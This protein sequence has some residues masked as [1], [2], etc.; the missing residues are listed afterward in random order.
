MI[1]AF[2]ANAFQKSQLAFQIATSP[3]VVTVDKHDGVKR[4]KEF[5]DARI[6]LH[7]LLERTFNIEY[8]LPVEEEGAVEAAAEQYVEQVAKAPQIDWERLKAD[9]LA[10]VRLRSAI[11][12][13]KLEQENADDDDSIMVM[14]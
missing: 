2:Q 3:I 1:T 9:V 4:R 12:A 14:H 10:D 6:R 13:Y 8:G 11:A 7:K 5:K